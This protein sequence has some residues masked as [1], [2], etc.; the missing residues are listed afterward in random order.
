MRDVAKSEHSHRSI[1]VKNS[2]FKILQGSVATLF[3]WN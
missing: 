3:R 1:S 2:Y